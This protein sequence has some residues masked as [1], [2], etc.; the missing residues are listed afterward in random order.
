MMTIVPWSD[1]N[2]DTL[3]A[4]YRHLLDVEIPAAQLSPSVP[5]SEQFLQKVS[6][7]QPDDVLQLIAWDDWLLQPTLSF[8]KQHLDLHEVISLQHFVSILGKAYEKI[9]ASNNS[10]SRV[11]AKLDHRVAL[12]D[13]PFGNLVVGLSRPNTKFQDR[14]FFRVSGLRPAVDL[15]KDAVLPLRQLANLCKLANARYGYIQ[16]DQDLVACCFVPGENEN[17]EGGVDK[18]WKAAIMPTPGLATE[19]S[20]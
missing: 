19:K 13:Y 8:D 6:I 5:R 2:L 18:N 20:S 17:D 9:E 10:N 7:R 16:T 3:N 12:D 11:V 15:V 1:F 4:S 14:Q